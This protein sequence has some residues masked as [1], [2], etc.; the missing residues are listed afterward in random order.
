MV[1][2]AGAWNELHLG[3]D[4]SGEIVAEV[5][6]DRNADDARTALSL[7]DEIDEIASFTADAAYDAL[8]IAQSDERRGSGVAGGRRNRDTTSRLA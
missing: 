5:L 4:R 1:V 6:T 8:V 7:V 2:A 3:V